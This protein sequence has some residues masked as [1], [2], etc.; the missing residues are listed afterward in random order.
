MD[1]LIAIGLGLALRYVVD[2]VVHHN[3]KL[4]GS[5]VGKSPLHIGI[6][7][8]SPTVSTLQGYGRDSL[9]ITS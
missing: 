9:F 1:N 2:L 7:R 5:L 3:I 6:G 8:P 4:G